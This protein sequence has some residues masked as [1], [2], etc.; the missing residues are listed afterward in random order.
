ML[1]IVNVRAPTTYLN[2]I[3]RIE[4]SNMLSHGIDGRV[5]YTVKDRVYGIELSKLVLNLI[6]G[7]TECVNSIVGRLVSSNGTRI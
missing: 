6:E 7:F 5:E 3:I 2:C 1:V 4:K